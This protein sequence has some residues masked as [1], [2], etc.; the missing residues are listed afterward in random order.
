MGWSFSFYWGGSVCGMGMVW[1]GR[2]MYGEADP[3]KSG[4]N[5]AC[6]SFN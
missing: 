6:Y 5:I 3:V 1:V 2:C 4:K